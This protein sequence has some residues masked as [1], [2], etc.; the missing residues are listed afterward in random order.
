MGASISTNSVDSMIENSIKVINTYEQSCIAPATEQQIIF[1]TDGCNFK[2]SPISFDNGSYIKQDCILN[3]TTQS[4]IS[5]SVTQAISQTATAITQQF[6]FGTVASANN[7]IKSAIKLG[8]EIS[9]TYLSK[10]VQETTDQSITFNCNNSTFVDGMVNFKNFNSTTQNCVLTALTDSKARQ[11]LIA[12]FAQS[13]YAKQESTFLY[14]LLAL[15]LFLA[16]GAWFLVSVAD[17]PLVQWSVVGL[18]FF[19]VVGS[20]IYAATAKNA[21]NYPYTKP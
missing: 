12:N 8:E 19:S 11:D 18:I 16:I 4:A 15:G 9:N 7:F 3:A 13:A 2:G 14:I 1:N 21:G 6:S 10:C 17:N 20:I 5:A